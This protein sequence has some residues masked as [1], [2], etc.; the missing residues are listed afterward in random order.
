M[1]FDI[2]F[3]PPR[4]TA[5]EK[6]YASRN[7]RI[8][9]YESE[10]AKEARRLLQMVLAPHAPRNPL[11]GALAL[12]VMWRFPYSGKSH[13]DGEYKQTRPDTDNLDKALKDVMTGLGYWADD[14]LVAREHIEKIWHKAHPGLF[15]RIKSIAA[16]KLIVI[17]EHEMDQSERKEQKNARIGI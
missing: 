13:Y 9:V 10:R 16:T 7:G 17:Q 6:K 4:S 5:Q 1:E 3:D 11:T 12:D 14:A 15:I 2:V 8:F